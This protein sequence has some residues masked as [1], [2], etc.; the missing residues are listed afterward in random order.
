MRAK[1][2]RLHNCATTCRSKRENLFTI[3]LRRQLAHSEEGAEV[4]RMNKTMARIFSLKIFSAFFRQRIFQVAVLLQQ[5]KASIFHWKL[6]FCRS[7]KCTANPRAC[8]VYQWNHPPPLV[9]FWPH[10]NTWC[11]CIYV[12]LIGV[13]IVTIYSLLVRKIVGLKIR[14]CRIV[15]KSHSHVCISGNIFQ[16]KC[17]DDTLQVSLKKSDCLGSFWQWVTRFPWQSFNIQ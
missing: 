16:L 17:C 12:V 4:Q 10:K 14:S 6:I 8:S 15:D 5:Q 2:A 7:S 11:Q 1:F 13:K 3:S 9:S